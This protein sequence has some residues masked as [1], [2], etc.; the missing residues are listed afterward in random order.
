MDQ[1]SFELPE[2]D[3]KKTQAAVEEVLEKYRVFKT[4]TFEEREASIT[5][6]VSDVPRSYTGTTSDQTADVAVHNVFV[7]EMRRSYCER[8]ER[9]V[10]K[11]YPKERLLIT[12]RYMKDERVTDLK[13]YSFVFNP[14]I[15]RDT[16]AKIRWTA[17]YSLAFNLDYFKIINIKDL[18][19]S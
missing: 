11:L 12:E 4:I 17:F 9:A 3:R 13:M 15:S 10:N 8:V 18:L 1:V 19:R 7:P 14:P 5:S 2:L 16:Y 6:S